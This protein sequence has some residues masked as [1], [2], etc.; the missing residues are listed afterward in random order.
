MAWGGGKKVRV[1]KTRPNESTDQ[2]QEELAKALEKLGFKGV[3]MVDI[4]MPDG[5]IVKGV[6]TQ[7]G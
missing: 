7:K 2:G 3:N 1:V 5:R 6:M 4:E